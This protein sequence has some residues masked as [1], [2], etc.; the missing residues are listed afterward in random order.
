MNEVERIYAAIPHFSQLRDNVLFGDVWKRPELTAAERSLVTCAVLAAQGRTQ[1]L[2]AHIQIAGRNG[3]SADQL[4]GL[5]VHVAF[6]AGW[7]AGMAIGR[8]ALEKI[9]ESAPA[10]R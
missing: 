8:A 1:E 7:P 9:E 2:Q 10:T 6:Y 3:V 5:A 4:R